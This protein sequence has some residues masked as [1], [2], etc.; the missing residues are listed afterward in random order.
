MSDNWDIDKNIFCFVNRA[1]GPHAQ[2][3]VTLVSAIQAEQAKNQGNSVG[4]SLEV[5]WAWGIN[6]D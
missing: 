5:N 4:F 1:E 6:K 3:V 2:A